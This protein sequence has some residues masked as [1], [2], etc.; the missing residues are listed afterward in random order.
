MYVVASNLSSWSD[1]KETIW[2]V[3]IFDDVIKY[4]KNIEKMAAPR[5]IKWSTDPEK[6]ARQ[7]EHIMR[8]MQKKQERQM[9]QMKASANDLNSLFSAFSSMGLNKTSK[10]PVRG[11]IASMS[12]TRKSAPAGKK[13]PRMS[14]VTQRKSRSPSPQMTNAASAA[15][16][17]TR[18]ERNAIQAARRMAA[19]HKK[20]VKNTM[21]T[22]AMADA[23][24]E[25]NMN[26][27]MHGRVSNSNSD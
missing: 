3:C 10:S 19:S 21:G 17:P 25:L 24:K 15:A 9:E 7:M 5:Q 1:A 2:C 26:S 13:G 18:E 20:R 6:K 27:H 11:T 4:K 14:R 8:S 12:A 23:L 16:R 22:H